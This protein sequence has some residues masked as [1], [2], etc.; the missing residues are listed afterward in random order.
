MKTAKYLIIN[1]QAL[2]CSSEFPITSYISETQKID[3]GGLVSFST[4]L[5]KDD[6]EV[7]RAVCYGELTEL[8]VF[9][10]GEKDAKL[11]EKQILLN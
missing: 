10:N 11:I 3:S 9:S 5:D 1:N 6:F 2:V 7:A 8:G 4:F